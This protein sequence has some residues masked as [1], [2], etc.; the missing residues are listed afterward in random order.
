VRVGAINKSWHVVHRLFGEAVPQVENE[1][2]FANLSFSTACDSSHPDDNT[3]QRQDGEYP[4]SSSAAS[5]THF[6]SSS[7]T[8]KFART[9]ALPLATWTPARFSH[10]T[11]SHLLN[12]AIAILWSGRTASVRSRFN[13]LPYRNTLPYTHNNPSDT[14]N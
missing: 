10:Q 3:R 5:S 4:Y 14:P 1:L 11:L 8:D 7:P 2:G 13:S 9:H 6:A 12:L